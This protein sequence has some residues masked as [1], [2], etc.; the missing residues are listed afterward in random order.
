MP[1][2]NQNQESSPAPASDP[3]LPQDRLNPAK[4]QDELA[5]ETDL[6]QG[7]FSGKAMF[8]SW[9]GAGTITL[10]VLA[11]LLSFEVLRSN[12]IAWIVAFS[13]VGL[14]WLYLFGILLNRKLGMHYQLTTQRLK[15]REGILFR[16]LDRIELID[17]DDVVYRQGP[18]QALLGVGNITI[19]SSDASHP[20]LVLYGIAN[21]REIA[22]LIDDARRQERRKRGLH[23]EAI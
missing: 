20:V 1:A 3:P 16:K 5:D 15:H 8:G 21:I 14:L 7:G 19:N 2:E 13:I 9:V 11:A 10:I 4:Q 12:S 22:D 18:I 6:W 17:I 23:I